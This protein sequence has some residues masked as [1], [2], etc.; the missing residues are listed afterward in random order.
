MRRIASRLAK[1]RTHLSTPVVAVSSE[2]LEGKRLITLTTRNG[3]KLEF[4][5]VVLACHSD[6]AFEMLRAGNIESQ[7][8]KILSQFRWNKNRAVL[9]CDP[10]V[11]REEFI[12]LSLIVPHS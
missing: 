9:H 6:T 5:H 10:A 7:E 2:K 3:E 4:D 8:D 1:D 12:R 11:S